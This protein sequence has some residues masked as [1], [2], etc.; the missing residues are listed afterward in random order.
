MT[1]KKLTV[2]AAIAVGIATCSQ[3]MA[4]C[5]CNDTLPVVTGPACPVETTM[6]TVTGSACPCKKTVP[7]CNSCKKTEKPP[8]EKKSMMQLLK[9][10]SIIKHTTKRLSEVSACRMNL[11]FMGTP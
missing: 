6:P 1:I 8:C 5:P 3:V 7:K 4:A 9:A 10:A 2:A 11:T